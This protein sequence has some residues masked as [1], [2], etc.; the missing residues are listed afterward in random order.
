MFFKMLKKD[1]RQK[2]LL[3]VILVLFIISACIMSVTSTVLIYSIGTGREK[4]HEICKT[5]DLFIVSSSAPSERG[6]DV[7]RAI[8]WFGM[9]AD[10]ADCSLKEIIRIPAKNVEVNG[11]PCDTFSYFD[12]SEIAI[13]T[14]PLEHNLVFDAD[15]LPLC[16]ENGNIALPRDCETALNVS[17]GDKIRI[18]TQMGNTCEFTVS[19]FYK[20]P[21]KSTLKQFIVS[22]SDYNAVAAQS[23][24]RDDMFEISISDDALPQSIIDAYNDLEIGSVIMSLYD[25]P[26]SHEY[27][28][29]YFI[30]TFVALVAVFMLLIIFITIRFT[31]ISAIKEE[32]CE[33]GMMRAIGAD[34]PHFRWLF[35]AKY[36]AFAVV[37][38]IIGIIAGIPMAE[39][40]LDMLCKNLFLPDMPTIIA[41]G[42]ITDL[43]FIASI[44]FF[45]LLV[46]R[47]IRKISVIDAIHGENKGERF[48]K[49]SRMFLHKIKKLSVPAY[50]AV[51]DVLNGFKRYV[52]L[53]VAYSLGIMIIL[54]TVHIRN[55]VVSR[56]YEKY[57]LTMDIDFGIDKSRSIWDDRVEKYGSMTAAIDSMNNDFESAGI[58]AKVCYDYITPGKCVMP[59]GEEKT[60]TL[61]FGEVDTEEFDYRT[62]GI[63]PKL[64][65]EIALSYNTANKYGLVVGDKIICSIDEY[66]EDGIGTKNTEREL[67][68]TGFVDYMESDSPIG[69]LGNDY[70]NACHSDYRIVSCSIYAPENQHSEYI[71]Q[72]NRLYGCKIIRTEDEEIYSDFGYV[73]P[74]LSAMKYVMSAVIILVF[75]LITT[76]YL[77]V[78]LSEE[79]L[80]VAM[81]KSFGMEQRSIKKWQVLRMCILLAISVIAGNILSVTLGQTIAQVIFNEI[82]GLSSFGFQIDPVQTYLIVPI[83]ICS[84]VLGTSFVCLNRHAHH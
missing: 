73:L 10:V 61:L 37:G 30:L 62:G 20:M 40:L 25:I 77:G 47:R 57:F 70:S 52:F 48:G 9:Q 11:T 29:M 16:V 41:I 74:I 26:L 4:T 63:A 79:K 67:L 78:L 80:S 66:A 72:M 1:L 84:V 24:L 56:E 71:N 76:L 59:N 51:S 53:V 12:F 5:S 13:A 21:V 49:A 31:M 68:I 82:T 54:C 33:I 8:E 58:P 15:N 36:I 2:K 50:L 3:N 7:K 22:E 34:S 18:T 46:M 55:T 75:V 83:L 17:L 23:P 69:I 19:R 32:E 39:T 45:S 81:L 64:K 65:N 35:V 28:I 60:L 38:G 27:S 14:C 43:I 42:I 44:I 6:E